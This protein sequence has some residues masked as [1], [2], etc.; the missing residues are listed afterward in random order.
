MGEGEGG[1]IW[2]N[3]IEICKL[4]HV[5]RIASQGS[6]YDTGCSGLVPREDPGR[7]DREGEGRGVLDGEHM[8]AYG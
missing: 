2:E 1:M 4:S 7:W 5:K 6:M 8:C 3:V